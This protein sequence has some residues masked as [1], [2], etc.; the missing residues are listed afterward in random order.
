MSEE[1]SSQE[2]DQE[3]D[4]PLSTVVEVDAIVTLLRFALE[5][6]YILDDGSTNLSGKL[7][8]ALN[9]AERWRLRLMH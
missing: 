5:W 7:V 3:I 9:E 4:E 8:R 2:D 6:S 1:S